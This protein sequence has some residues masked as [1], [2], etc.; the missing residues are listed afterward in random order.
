MKNP[1][2]PPVILI[3]LEQGGGPL[4]TGKAPELIQ[5]IH[6]PW[7][8]NFFEFEF[9][10]LNFTRPGNNEYAYFLEGFE[11]QWNRTETRRYG[12]YTNQKLEEMVKERTLALKAAKEK[13][14]AA[15]QAKGEFLANMSH[16]I[17]TP[18]NLLIGFS[19]I[20]YKEVQDEVIKEY[21][22]TIGS[23]LCEYSPDQ[24]A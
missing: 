15:S 8:R 11:T 1:Y 19:D 13:A 10:V 5:S 12:K 9:S 4:D 2:V 7:Q 3:S 17:R 18:L 6:L 21:V 22:A 16:E 14:E 20:I 23:A 24:G